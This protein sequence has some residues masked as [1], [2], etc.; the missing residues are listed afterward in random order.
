MRCRAISLRAGAAFVAL[1]FSA[2]SGGGGGASSAAP[3]AAGVVP[4]T[5]SGNLVVA[6]SVP[7]THPSQSKAR[8]PQ[9]VSPSTKSVSIAINGGTAQNFNITNGS[10]GCSA[11]L[12][13]PSFTEWAIGSGPRG[14]TIGPDG[15]VWIVENNSSSTGEI[16]TSGANPGSYQSFYA[17]ATDNMVISGPDGRLWLAQLYQTNTN[18]NPVLSLTTSGTYTTSNL[19]PQPQAAFWALGSD[20]ALWYT[21]FGTPANAIYRMT[22]ANGSAMPAGSYS[23]AGTTTGLTGGSDGNIWF[24]ESTGGNAWVGRLTTGGA[25]TEFPVTPGTVPQVGI[26]FGSDGALWFIDDHNMVNRMTTTGTVTNRY[27]ITAGGG[28]QMVSGPDGAL[29]FTEYSSGMIGRITT[30]G[31]LSEF[32]IPTA[33]SLPNGIAFAADG[34][35]YF[36]ED[37]NSGKAGRLQFPMNCTTTANAPSGNA[38]VAVTTYDATGGAAGTGHALSTQTLPVTVAANGQ[39]TLSL[40]LNGIVSSVT[41]AAGT[42]GALPCPGTLPLTLEA[43]DAAGNAIVGPG[44]YVDASGNPVTITLSK[45]GGGTLS[46]PTTFT[47]P[48]AAQ[49]T[50]TFNIFTTANISAAITTGTVPGGVTGSP[51]AVN[52]G[53]CG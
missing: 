27:A 20:G 39:T 1:A 52:G 37:T 44:N 5:G 36:S 30:S 24:T 26:A 41:L 7:P 17:G 42:S 38:T 32:P 4:V 22:V 14:V 28:D 9:F 53:P 43:L 3:H 15:N 13:Q 40:T 10:P 19:Y 12:A 21:P 18:Y 49:P 2:C 33:N 31:A 16:T 11:N 25:L 29:W 46:T 35:L 47:A 51:L 48:P 45:T 8:K 6:L 50:W 34:S 23:T